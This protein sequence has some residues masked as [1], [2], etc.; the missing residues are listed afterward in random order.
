MVNTCFL[1]RSLFGETCK[2]RQVTSVALN[3]SDTLALGSSVVQLK[4][5]VKPTKAV[6]IRGGSWRNFRALTPREN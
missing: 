3:R 1:K 5:K 4:S 6:W 2:T